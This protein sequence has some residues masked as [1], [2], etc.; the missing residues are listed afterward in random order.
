MLVPSSVP[1]LNPTR[2]WDADLVWCWIWAME[3]Y[4][5]KLCKMD[6]YGFLA[7]CDPRYF[8]NNFD[9]VFVWELE[10][11]CMRNHFLEHVLLKW[12]SS[13]GAKALFL[14][15]IS[16]LAFISYYSPLAVF[17]FKCLL[18]QLIC[19]VAIKQIRIHSSHC[20]TKMFS[21]NSV[22]GSPLKNGLGLL[23]T[24]FVAPSMLHCRFLRWRKTGSMYSNAWHIF[25]WNYF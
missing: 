23:S 5:N 7:F 24:N 20:I 10:P 12:V 21:E 22:A 6:F 15:R 19:V 1:L 13:C 2:V 11:C 14:I 18:C 3:V 4:F 17:T 8:L 9:T 25:V 16:A